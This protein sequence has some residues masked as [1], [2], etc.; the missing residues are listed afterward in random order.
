MSKESDEYYTPIEIIRALGEFDLDPACGP[1]CPNET[2]RLMYRKDGLERKWRGRV[3]LNPPYSEAKAWSERFVQ[4]GNGII[5]LFWS[6]DNQWSKRL[7]RAAGAF[8]LFDQRINFRKPDGKVFHLPY[9]SLLF[10]IGKANI[11]SIARSGL[12]GQLLVSHHASRITP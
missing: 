6:R 2:A 4:H 12:R 8:F 5:L 7:L 11:E 9:H 1:R 10:P 3:W